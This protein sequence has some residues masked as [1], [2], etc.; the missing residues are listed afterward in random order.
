MAAKGRAPKE[1]VPDYAADVSAD[2]ELWLEDVNDYLAICG[3]TTNDDKKMLFL[4]LAGLA[5]RKVVK[6]L[7]IPP[8]LGA[9]ADN[10]GD[11]YKALTDAV[12]AH[13]RPSV[14]TTSER[15]KFRQLRQLP[16]E[17]VS[18]FIA[19]L[20]SKVDLCEFS[21]T[22]VD[23]VENTQIRDQLIVGL[24]SSEIRRE[25][26]KESKLTLSDAITKAVALETSQIDSK[27]YQDDTPATRTSNPI[28]V[29]AEDRAKPKKKIPSPACKYCGRTHARGKQHCPAAHIRCHDCGKVGHFSAVC[30]SSKTQSGANAVDDTESDA[31]SV[32]YDTIYAC[33]D[34][35]SRNSFTITL[36][37][38]GKASEGLMDTGATRTI[39][40]DDVVQATRPSDR[41][42]KAYNS[43]VIETLG[44]ADVNIAI[45]NDTMECTC[46]VV[47]HG[48]RRVLFGQDVISQLQLLVS[49]H[50]VDTARLVDTSPVSISVDPKAHP[51]T[52][53][54]RRPPF[55]A[56]ADI[57]KELHRLVEADVIE[58]V[59]QASAW[60]SP[61]V[62]VRKSSGKLR[63]CVDYREL[64]KSIVRERHSLPT[65][66]EIT[67]ELADAQV[68]SV[69]DAESG[70]HQLLLDEDSRPL[71]T[72]AT[73][74]G[75]F[76]FKRLPFG[77]SCAPEIFQRVVSDILSGLPGVM[78]YIDDILVFG[79]DRT[80]HDQRLAA[81]LDRLKSANLKLNEDKCCIRQEE[82]KYL[83]HVLTKDGVQPDSDKLSAIQY[84]APPQSA[85]DVQR[86][87][88][89]V[90]YLGKFIP[91]LTMATEP[92]RTLLK[93]GPFVVDEAV[94]AAYDAVK[95]S[96]A[97]SLSTLAYFQPAPNVPTA[98]SCDA[99]P[100][101]LG[102][103]LWQQDSSGQ[104]L[105]VTCA[106]RSLAD[107]E[108][109]YSQL[110][111]EMLGVVLALTR[112][113]Q[114][115]LGRHVD[116]FTD[117]KPLLSIVRKPFDDV[118]PR[119]QRWLVALMPYGYNLQHVPGKQL[120]CTDALSRAPLPGVI[121]SPA[122]SRSLHEYVGLV[123][124]AAPVAIDDIRNATVDDSLLSKVMQRVLTSSWQNLL[125]SEQPYNLIRD[126]LTV[127]EGVVM[128]SARFVI[129][130]A[131]RPS[132]MALA[133]EGHPGREAFHDV[134]RQ[135]VWWPGLTKDATLY[136]ERC[137]ECWR[138]RSNNP[139]ELLPSEVEG[140][141]EKL[142]VDLV[143]IEGHSV[144]SIIDYGS[145]F[146]IL[147]PLRSTSASAVIDELDDVFAMFGLPSAMVSDNGPQFASEH[148]VKFLTQLGIR[149]IKSSPR[150]PKSNGMVERLHRVLRERL[151]AMKSHLPFQRR[152]NQVL[153]DIRSSCHRMLGVSPGAALFTRN[154]RIR[155]PAL[156]KPRLVNPEHQLKAKADMADQHDSRRG[157]QN[158]TIL[159]PGSKVII[160]GGYYSP[161]QPWTVVDQYGRQ[162]AVT[163]GCRFLLRNRQHVREYVPPSVDL[164]VTTPLGNT[165]PDIPRPLCESKT[166]TAPVPVA[167]TCTRTWNTSSQ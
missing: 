157:V 35:T 36:M 70:F 37:V 79:R 48:T 77:V 153:F 117:H 144:L 126:Q 31:A 158:L 69:L 65:I 13:F 159:K 156:I 139:Q 30:L 21:S 41:T 67:A 119:L 66:E 59:K 94:L 76:R 134:L 49:N 87:L 147:R 9:T 113:R 107:A 26:L 80:E 57:E 140:V 109:R 128:M 1:F 167:G 146:P 29:V 22:S 27:L 81:V 63:L 60:V 51:V 84:M 115:V 138:R 74:C 92:L 93:R 133:H 34:R 141:W 52:Q 130:E 43:G 61:I 116:V 150:Y 132:V 99:S 38:N 18:G 106:S 162:V 121:P 122:E 143:S 46:F 55:S 8:P 39:V 20:R 98:V 112:F 120:F 88:G 103:I 82:V 7:V 56:K 163:D 100:C 62:P 154:M 127:V 10:P 165:T 105:P 129:P 90:T 17:S 71:T 24:K 97:G 136:V 23:S 160:Q 50:L 47:P 75:L 96:V 114:Y 28:A 4:N 86:F 164:E 151:S 111:R 3:V 25:L 15:H 110:E 14:N 19:R 16:D 131:L 152:L 83:G 101:G 155:V 45:G 91:Q 64:N 148:M 166:S 78:V 104:W 89:M 102:A 125:P 118:P 40:T 95:Q 161:T 72:F 73:H 135:R 53:P 2:F 124:E 42:L 32:V 54:A 6:G 11:T 12:R 145:R 58:P 142:A 137:S 5:V 123:L 44:M 68:F 149:H 33:S 108:T 85:A